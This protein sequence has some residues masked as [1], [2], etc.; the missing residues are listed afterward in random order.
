MGLS[1]GVAR[2]SAIMASGTIVSRVTGVLRDV[3]MT[4]ALGLGVMSD[5]YSLGNTIPNMMYTLLIGGALQAVFVP[6]L[7]RHMKDDEDGGK[8]FSD[9]LLTLSGLL[10][11]GITVACVAL[12]PL[13][14]KLYATN[15]YSD[16]ELHVATMFA[17]YCLPQIFFYGIFTMLSQVLY[18]R[19]SFGAPMFAPILNNIISIG[20]FGAFIAMWGTTAASGDTLTSQQ[21][22]LTG[23]G[24][25]LGVAAQALILFPY[26]RRSG[27][28]FRPRFEFRGFGMGKSFDLGK[29]TIGVVLLNQTSL[30]VVTR[31]ATQANIYAQEN[32]LPPGGLT[33]LQKAHLIFVLPHSL[34]T[35]SLVTALLPSMSRLASENRLREIGDVVGNAMR[36]IASLVVPIGAVMIPLA[37]SIASLLFG[38]GAAA[39]GSTAGNDANDILGSTVLLYTL[40]LV[41]YTLYYVLIRGWYSMEDTKSV[42]MQGILLNA[43]TIALAIGLYSL[44]PRVGSLALAYALSYWVTFL[45][46][47]RRLSLRLGHLDS[48]RTLWAL[49]RM[50]IAGVFASL[51]AGF[52]LLVTT[53]LLRFD[54]SN[55]IAELGIVAVSG[56][57]G[58]AA[59]LVVSYLLRV[60][61][62]R[63]AVAM[64]QRRFKRG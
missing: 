62:V 10:L 60:K 16:S 51:V 27:Y 31:L 4:A 19:E 32:G 52:V 40:G 5:A 46:A 34:V 1:S 20:V 3:A 35:V 17:Y 33:T 11:L 41:P 2:N 25:T 48:R 21:V 58:V 13:L 44:V 45:V 28:S 49:T 54:P 7:I 14:T 56:T 55:K 15:S 22:A 61:E 36:V 6:Q 9:R 37:P 63:D 26:A 24:T 30:L 43:V 12:A 50:I 64:V 53:D 29:W 57:A 38:Y 8:A 47:W 18:A 42:F 59:Y 39:G 23:V